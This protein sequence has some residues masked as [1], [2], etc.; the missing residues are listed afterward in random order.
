MSQLPLTI[1]LWLLLVHP[2]VSQTKQKE[3]EIMS[4]SL[5]DA[6]YEFCSVTKKHLIKEKVSKKDLDNYIKYLSEHMPDSLQ[7]SDFFV[8][9]TV[10]KAQA[11][12]NIREQTKDMIGSKC[13]YSFVSW[14]GWDGKTPFTGFRFN[15][16]HDGYKDQFLVIVSTSNN[17]H[18]LFSANSKL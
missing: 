5:W 10:S 6:V 8:P 2:I 1:L 13:S 12:E 4:D 15:I 3:K 11:L 14:D 17:I 9:Y 7:S 16:N 18:C